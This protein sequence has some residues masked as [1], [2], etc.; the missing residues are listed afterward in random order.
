MTREFSLINLEAERRTRT[1][2]ADARQALKIR[3]KRI[4]Y[5][6]FDLLRRTPSPVGKNDDLIVREVWYR[7]NR[8][9]N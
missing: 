3:D 8:R 1:H 5:L 4:S 7:I 2:D 9:V 6:V